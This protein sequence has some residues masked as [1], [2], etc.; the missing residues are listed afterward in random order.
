[1]G[2]IMTAFLN[3]TPLIVILNDNEMSI[4]PNVGA[5]SQYLNKLRLDPTL[6]KLRGEFEH[7][8]IGVEYEAIGGHAWVYRDGRWQSVRY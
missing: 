7:D 1:M 6:Y 8:A 4:R 3:K 2:N 5:I